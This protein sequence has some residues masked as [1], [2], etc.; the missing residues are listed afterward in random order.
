MN[1]YPRVR[2]TKNGW[3][4]FTL[5]GYPVDIVTENIRFLSLMQKVADKKLNAAQQAKFAEIAG[6]IFAGY[7][8][9][10]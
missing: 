4:C 2:L 10:K 9:L 1:K 3:G 7:Y 6:Q 5:K 8:P